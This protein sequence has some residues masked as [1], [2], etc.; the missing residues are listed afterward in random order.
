MMHSQIWFI[1]PTGYLL[2]QVRE[3]L[4]R[5]QFVLAPLPQ[6]SLPK[7][8]P[9]LLLADLSASPEQTL[10]TLESLSLQPGQDDIRI[11][12][13]PTSGLEHLPRA[14]ARA[15]CVVW[16]EHEPKA[17][18]VQ[19]L[20]QLLDQYKAIRRKH[21]LQAMIPLYK[22]AQSLADL[23]D[24]N[25]VLHR[26]LQTAIE[27]TGA[28][29]GSI[30]LLEE[31]SNLLYI[32]AAVGLPAHIVREQRQQVGEGIAGWVV[33]HRKPLVLTEGEIPPFALPWL[34]GR[35]AYSSVSLPLI[36]QNQVLGVLN[37]TKEPGRPP[38]QEGDVEFISILAAQT[39]AVIHNVRLF[40]QLQ[41]AYQDL[42]Q[43]DRLRTQIIDIAAHELRT[44]VT[45]IRGYFDLLREAD[46]PA[47]APFLEPIERHLERLEALAR[48]LFDLSSLRSLERE[49]EPRAIDVAGWLAN[50]LEEYRQLAE[51]K[52]VRLTHA[53]SQEITQ[54]VFDPEY[55]AG[56]L[57]HLISNALKFTPSGGQVSVTVER[58]YGSLLFHV[59]DSGPGIPERERERV[60]SEFYQV[61]EV[62]TREHEGLGVG[63]SLARALARAHQGTIEIGDS[64]I[65]G[66]RVTVLIPENLALQ[67]V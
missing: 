60:F 10:A 48:D 58:K 31:E 43:L 25:T 64:P 2:E 32:G 6:T 62:S 53:V 9:F 41:R 14:L 13:V 67:D 34:R 29:R 8:T 21:R 39:A 27:E 36:H 1:S 23:D 50:Y 26:V 4:E 46:I 54:A 59:D 40:M 44:P 18:L 16:V 45:V 20:R 42:Q 38:F 55:L 15:L 12:L 28:D 66:A 24:L 19:R 17:V 49:P 56:I 35:N 11:V 30:M 22:L 3:V 37:L 5:E 51:N 33:Q 65:G 63:L 61:E 52:G 7:E 47:I 57:R